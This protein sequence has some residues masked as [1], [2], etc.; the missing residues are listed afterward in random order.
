[1]MYNE[2]S[3]VIRPRSIARWWNNP[4]QRFMLAVHY[5]DYHKDD[6]SGRTLRPVDA[7]KV[8]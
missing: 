4:K 2:T 5:V 1:M 6:I 3:F 8:R 7:Q